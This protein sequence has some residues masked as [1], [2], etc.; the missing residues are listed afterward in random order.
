MTSSVM[1]VSSEKRVAGRAGCA[2]CVLTVLLPV[3]ASAAFNP[4]QELVDEAGATV[5]AFTTDAGMKEALRELGSEV[6]AVFIL[7]DF[8]RWGFL[9]GGASGKGLLIVRDEQTGLWSQP[10]FYNVASMNNGAQVGADVPEIIVVV[11]SKKGVEEFYGAGFKLGAG[12]G[13][14]VGPTGTG[15]SAHG[16]NADMLAYARKKGVF[17]GVALGG[18][19]ITVAENANDAYY[20]KPVT[21][22]EI[23]EG[24]VSNLR[25]LELRNA[26]RKLFE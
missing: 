12:A 18:A 21:P 3:L 5:E 7:P 26:T 24:S 25:S 15:T 4:Q 1:P 2:L 6:R 19:L 8:F 17:G 14:A 22:R 23:I 11:R 9:V 20:G 13:L 16:L 10:V